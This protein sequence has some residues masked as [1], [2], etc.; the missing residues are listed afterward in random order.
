[1][2][3]LPGFY[4][5][6]SG[7]FGAGWGWG[8]GYVS[9]FGF[10]LG[11][12]SILSLLAAT[13]ANFMVPVAGLALAFFGRLRSLRPEGKPEVVWGGH[14]WQNVILIDGM[15]LAAAAYPISTLVRFFMPPF[16]LAPIIPPFQYADPWPVLL[17]G[18][19]GFVVYPMLL[20]ITFYFLGRRIAIEDMN[21]YFLGIRILIVGVTGLLI[22]DLVG[23]YIESPDR[24]LAILDPA[25]LPRTALFL[26][27]S[28]LLFTFLG[29][30]SASLGSARGVERR[31]PA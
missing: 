29:L 8:F 31:P 16:S 18:Y 23:G 28:G 10:G 5:A 17:P 15:V 3:N 21:L 6:T 22:G 4:H 11:W 24:F 7:H 30:G 25:G 9:S 1:M 2:G 19:A 14:F 27:T 26:F 13:V 20:L 12:S